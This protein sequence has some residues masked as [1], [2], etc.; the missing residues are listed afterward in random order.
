MTFTSPEI[1]LEDE[2]ATEALAGRISELLDRGDVI[3]L[4]GPIGSGKSLFARALIR[5]RLG[6]PREE[7]PSPT[8]TI[9]QTYPDRGGDIWHCDLYRLGSSDEIAELGLDEALSDA[10]C[11][12]EWPDRLGPERPDGALDLRLWATSAG[13]KAVFSGPDIWR[14]RLRDAFE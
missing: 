12:I 11:L 2:A 8:F 1:V 14:E 6:N 4:H 10:I 5:A 9:V 7:V 13:H 3:L